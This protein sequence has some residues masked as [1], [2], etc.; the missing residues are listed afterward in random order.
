MAIGKTLLRSRIIA[1]GDPAT[2]LQHVN[3]ELE[4]NNETCMFITV[5]CGIL[6]LRTNQLIY[7]NAGH[8]P[9]VIINDSESGFMPPAAAPPLGAMP[10]IKFSNATMQ[11][12]SGVRLLL[13]T[14]GVT[15]AMDVNGQL[16]GNETLLNLVRDMRCRTTEKCVREIR[17]TISSFAEN[18]EQYDDITMLCISNVPPHDAVNADNITVVNHR[19]EYRR[20]S[21]W[22]EHIASARDWSVAITNS[23]NL[24]LEEWFVNLISYAFDDDKIHEIE[25]ALNYTDSAI[26]I[27]VTDD[28]KPFDPTADK[29]DDLTAPLEERKIGG[30]GIHFIRNTMDEFTYRREGNLN[31]VTMRKNFTT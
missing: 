11:L 21:T 2:T 26:E 4:D 9:P 3:N 31:V 14:D 29:P 12:P 27:K 8:N 19:D 13:Y 7:A 17:S 30:L 1:T 5:F 25:I 22:L 23:I 15:E 24:A 20:L 18:A 10:D 28:G 6:D 16:F